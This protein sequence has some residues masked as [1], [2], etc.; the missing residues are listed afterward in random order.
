MGVS[1]LTRSPSAPDSRFPAVDDAG[2]RSG[3]L[4]VVA[5]TTVEVP[6]RVLVLGMARH[7]GTVAMGSLLPVAE[8]CGQ[9]AEQVRSCLRR[10]VAEGLLRPGRAAAQARRLRR[11]RRPAWPRSAA[12]SSAPARLRPGRRRPGLG[13]AAGG[14]SP[15][16]SPRRGAAARDA[17]R[18]RLLALGGAADPQRPL[19]VAAPVGQGRRAAEAE[20][21]GVGRRASPSRRTD[22]LEV[23]GVRDPRELARRL[24]PV[25]ELA[26]ALRA[27]RR[28]PT[29]TCPSR[30]LEHARPP[31]APPRRRVPARRA[32][33]WPSPSRTCFDDDPLLPPEL[34][35]RPWPGRAARDAARAQPP[36]RA[37]APRG[38]RPAR[39]CSAASTTS[40]SRSPERSRPRGDR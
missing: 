23:G 15:S 5:E 7:D 25:D 21:L 33:P 14:S 17:F 8:A 12:T 29:A 37:R 28:R 16:P 36:P 32:R 38:A 13:P 4:S 9:T 24:W 40:S 35:P 11:H 19:R 26:D 3:R 31:R 6:T 27:L 20:R 1:L 39:A 34:L 18:D 2:D 30:S 10:L 22:D